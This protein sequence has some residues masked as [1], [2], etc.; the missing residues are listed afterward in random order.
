MPFCVGGALMVIQHNLQAMNS[1]RMLDIN[2]NNIAISAEK[3]SSGYRINKAADDAAG[4][5][6]SEKMRK[7]IRGLS[8]ASENSEDGISCIQTAEGALA[9]VQDMLQRMNQLCVQAA[10]G[11]NSIT[12]RKYIQDELDQLIS[13]IDR[14]SETTKF[15]EIYL[16]KGDSDNGVTNRYIETYN[17]SV[18]IYDKLTNVSESDLS[19]YS[20]YTDS[21][22]AT[23]YVLGEGYFQ[24]SSDV[25]GVILDISGNSKIENTFLTNVTVNCASDTILSINNVTIDNS[26]YTHTS[27]DGIGSAIV[28]NDGNSTLNCFGDNVIKGGWQS[29]C[30]LSSYGCAGCGIEMKNDVAL[31]I[32]GTDTSTLDVA[33]SEH[34]LYSITS[35]TYGFAGISSAIGGK[36]IK[37]NGNH[38]YF[39]SNNTLNINSGN[40]TLDA[41]NGRA[42]TYMDNSTFNFNGGIIRDDST[43][44]VGT[45]NSTIN[46]NGSNLYSSRCL[47]SIAHCILNIS[48]GNMYTNGLL[49]SS[50][51]GELGFNTINQTGGNI[52]GDETSNLRY[53]P[54]ELTFSTYNLSG[55]YMHMPALDYVFEL[56]RSYLY[57]DG[58]SNDGSG[59]DMGTY[60]LFEYGTR[61]TT[62]GFTYDVDWND[63]VS[64]SLLSQLYDADGNEI[65]GTKLNDYFSNQG[66]YEGGLFTSK[67]PTATDEIVSGKSTTIWNYV[68]QQV[69]KANNPAKI[70]ILA[71]DD[72]NRNNTIEMDISSLSAVSLD[73][74]KL[75][76]NYIGIVDDT[77]ALATDSINIVATAIQRVSEQRSYLGAIQNRLRHTIKNIDNVVEN[78]TSAES[79]IRDTDMADEMVRYAN[80][81]ILVQA[82]QAMLAQANQSKEGILNLLA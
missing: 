15:N 10:N 56:N 59:T 75:N 74:L 27:T 37:I 46:I 6:I 48:E 44:L 50:Y 43:N 62:S 22:G 51:N 81:N 72:S 58:V 23:H 24:I 34:Y 47:F 52:I 57:V 7:Q 30:A 31:S 25:T 61:L 45:Y 14:V 19:K 11:T 3:L 18:I 68:N 82:G 40:L 39:A 53:T 21:D 38:L 29:N 1:N 65:S 17:S 71:G 9:E 41:Q 35:E 2:S 26:A 76:S 79:E 77:G 49:G 80:N 12:D 5:A 16:L 13:E 69:V 67:Q 73:I 60:K 36:T 8:R 54:I 4:L 55:G 78:T 63:L 32:N 20:S 64:I 66:D 33:S 42:I 28:F 70:D